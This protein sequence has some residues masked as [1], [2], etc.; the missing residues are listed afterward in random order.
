MS[1]KPHKIEEP[2]AAYRAPKPAKGAATA[3]GP[4]QVDDATFK[5]ITEKIF[6]ERKDLLRKLAQ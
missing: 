4:R 6:T 1:K 5:R 2:K 3:A